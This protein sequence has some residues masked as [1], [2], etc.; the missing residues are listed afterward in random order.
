VTIGMA[1][2]SPAIPLRRNKK[3]T[4]FTSLLIDGIP[5]VLVIFGLVEFI[6][7]MG[8]T[9]KLLTAI[10][11]LLGLIFGLAYRLTLAMPQGFADW[12]SAVIFGLALG[13]VASGF[14]NFADSRWPKAS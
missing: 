5:L 7:H 13:L 14:Y 8:M 12:F 1:G 11:L 2:T 6:K 10:S 9:G 3:M 4:D